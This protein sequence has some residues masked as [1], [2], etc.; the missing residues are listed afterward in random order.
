MSVI[1]KLGLNRP[2]RILAFCL[3]VM[4]LI[5]SYITLKEFSSFNLE[6]ITSKQSYLLKILL[7]DVFLIFLLACIV[8][9]RIW[10]IYLNKKKKMPGYII[11]YRLTILFGVFAALPA[12]SIAIL[13]GIYMHTSMQGWFNER[14]STA[15]GESSEV[16]QA[17]LGEH[18]R[19]ILVDATSLSQ[20]MEAQLERSYQ[21]SHSS[22][23]TASEIKNNIAN[24]IN[25]ALSN[26]SA[27]RKIT[28]AVV[29]DDA[30]DVIFRSFQTLIF[31]RMDISEDTFEKASQGQAVVLDN[32]ANDRRVRALIKLPISIDSLL[33]RKSYLLIGRPIDAEVLNHVSK[34]Q[35][36]SDEYNQLESQRFR[37]QN[38]LMLLYG[39]IASLFLLASL[40]LGMLIAG[41]ISRPLIA[42][43]KAS[44][45]VS[46]GDLDAHVAIKDTQ[47][48]LSL[49]GDSFN[50]MT[51]QLKSQQQSLM[52]T[53]EELEERRQFIE[54]ILTGVSAGVISTDVQ[55][56]ITLVN[57]Q[58]EK[59]LNI[60]ESDVS[61][62]NIYELLPEFAPLLD[63]GE[64]TEITINTN[65]QTR[66][67][68]CQIVTEDIND[69]VTGFIITF[70][71]ITSLQA[72]ERKAAWS[73]VARRI[74]H[75]IK[76]PLTPIQLSAERLQRR[77][78][79]QIPEDDEVF[80]LCLQTIIRQVDQ[81]GRLV[82][83]FSS[84]ARLPEPIL[85]KQNVSTLIKGVFE[86]E[87]QRTDG[88]QMKLDMPEHDII[89]KIDEGLMTQ[90]LTNLLK[91]AS[92]AAA[93]HND[94]QKPEIDIILKDMESEDSFEISIEDNGMG[95]PQ[96]DRNH[97]LEPY[98]TTK[99]EGTGLGLAIVQKIIQDH[100][101]ELILSDSPKLKGAK[102]ILRFPKN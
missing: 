4:I 1:K 23:L 34:T 75:E 79:K 101:G 14:I 13:A 31:G 21:R 77:Y 52:T 51:A 3:G 92:E 6:N 27:D 18:Q 20:V 102:V 80:D 56:N 41:R 72:A 97:I 93:A 58:A 7:I 39:I 53:N 16:A 30:G 78:K 25:L 26:Q 67:L 57:P 48:E 8:F 42:L 87:K 17:Y 32:K 89:A 71:D 68:Q 81:I 11:R 37:A 90:A 35:T 36:A 73:G 28:E 99:K 43:I 45:S 65:N 50:D 64:T 49:L 19:T 22:F 94:E 54:T 95:F 40:W 9:Y 60:N 63:S 88:L 24:D 85:Q 98:V 55:K 5:T 86:L 10:Q 38:I 74:A 44:K 96:N 61:G 2:A 46:M 62:K 66:I 76:N 15:I 47:D 29:I 59:L 100:H 83:E 91:N 69:V 84:F 33:G 12:V 82:Q 70:D